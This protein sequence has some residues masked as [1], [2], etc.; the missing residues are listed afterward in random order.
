[1]S[2]S[3]LNPS[4]GAQADAVRPCCASKAEQSSLPTRPVRRGRFGWLR[5]LAVAPAAVLPL[6]PSFTCPFCIAAYAGTLSALGLG[7]LLNESVLAPL[8]AVFLVVGIASIAW[9]S[10][11]HRRI[12]P[13]AGA[14][15]GSALVVVGRLIWDL[16]IVLYAGVGL[17]VLSSLWNLWLKRPRRARLVQ[18]GVPQPSEQAEGAR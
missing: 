15:V 7:F 12:G 13:L 2:S 17:L 8:I 10:R 16:P 11:S 6:L 1:M 5:P 3:D 18:I 14:I 4:D 9:T